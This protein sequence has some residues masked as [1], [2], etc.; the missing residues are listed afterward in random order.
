M[1]FA[2]SVESKNLNICH[3]MDRDVVV[4]RTGN[5]V[6]SYTSGR[7]QIYLKV[8]R[9]IPHFVGVLVYY[10]ATRMTFKGSR[11]MG[12]GKLLDLRC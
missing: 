10:V 8:G 5:E 1:N 6:T 4:F 9:L 2:K 3:K 11:Q 12:I 7:L